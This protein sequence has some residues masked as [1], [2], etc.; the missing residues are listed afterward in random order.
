MGVC[1]P[2]R[3]SSGRSSCLHRP[4]RRPASRFVTSVLAGWSLL[5]VAR[6]K[7]AWSAHW[8]GTGAAIKLWPA[9]LWPALCGGS[10]RQK[11]RASPVSAMAGLLAPV[12]VDLGRLGPAPV[13]LLT[14]QSACVH[15]ESAWASIQM[16]G[17]ALGLGDYGDHLPLPGVE[18]RGTGWPWT[19][20][21]PSP[22]RRFV[23]IV[24]AYARWWHRGAG[25]TRWRWRSCCWSSR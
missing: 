17:R 15:V 13:S 9:L 4:N 16:L 22:P 10:S 25:S 23:G 11:F 19:A 18:A 21:S 1:E 12:F 2:T 7:W 3:S 5:L 20:R 6:R 24:V 8:A 14:W